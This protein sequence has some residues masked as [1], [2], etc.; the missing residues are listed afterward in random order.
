MKRRI[1]ILSKSFLKQLHQSCL[2]KDQALDQKL[3]SP[4]REFK[5]NCEQDFYFFAKSFWEVAQ[6]RPFIKGWHVRIICKLLQKA[7]E[8]KVRR[9]IINIPPRVGKSTLVSVLFPA[10]VWAK[11]PALR[12]LYTSY[13][14][15][16][17]V[18]DSA[19]TRRLI[20]SPE[21]QELWGDQFALRK[22]VDNKIKF[23]NN[24]GGVRLATSVKGANTGS[25]G[26]F[27]VCFPGHTQILTE[28]G[29]QSIQSIV[30]LKQPIKVWTYHNRYQEFQLKPVTYRFKSRADILYHLT[31]E[32][33][34]KISATPEHPFY[35]DLEK[36]RGYVAARELKVGDTLYR[37]AP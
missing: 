34:T 18:R 28:F 9:L 31:L 6:G 36:A 24:K 30:D 21:Y 16:I 37:A 20:R 22:D 17:S 12:F 19:A 23:E 11:Q 13:S 10:W 33:G 15:D 4:Q 26:D 14:R 7:Y 35:T 5:I 8:G 27:I 32:D 29:P 2:K 1:K 25:G 3:S